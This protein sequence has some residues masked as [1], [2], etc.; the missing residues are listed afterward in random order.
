VKL[1]LKKATDRKWHHRFLGTLAMCVIG[2]LPLS[3]QVQVYQQSNLLEPVFTA[4]AFQNGSSSGSLTVGNQVEV[5][6]ITDIKS[7][8]ING[9]EFDEV[10][11]A[12]FLSNSILDAKASAKLLKDPSV[13]FNLEV[14]N[15]TGFDQTTTLT[16]NLPFLPINM[17]GPLAG[18]AST[19]LPR[20]MSS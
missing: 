7:A 12:A 16:V 13:C 14:T 4:A 20:W 19:C 1:S 10:Q 15:L 8:K 3:A 2:A 5:L 6:T 9:D 17:G 18:G 11:A